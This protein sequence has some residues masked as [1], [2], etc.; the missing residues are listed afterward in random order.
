MGSPKTPGP[1]IERLRA[2]YQTH[3]DPEMATILNQEGLR[4][5]AGNLFTARIVGDTRRRNQLP[6]R[7]C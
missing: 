3:T 4:T 6:K 7:E 1:I 2:L 5:S